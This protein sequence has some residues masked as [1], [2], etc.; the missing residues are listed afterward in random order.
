MTTQQKVIARDAPASSRRRTKSPP[1]P[2][3]G[4]EPSAPNPYCITASPISS[5]SVPFPPPPDTPP[6]LVDAWQSSQPWESVSGRLYSRSSP[7]IS[8]FAPTH[9]STIA[10]HS[11][12]KVLHSLEASYTA[13]PCHPVIQYVQDADTYA[14]PDAGHPPSPTSSSG[15]YMSS[16]LHP[17]SLQS[18]YGYPAHYGLQHSGVSHAPS[19]MSA[20]RISGKSLRFLTKGLIVM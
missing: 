15:G 19:G 5:A 8:P 18:P 2:L 12:A 7:E 1:L 6:P 4:E 20:A 16:Q 13:S 10:P 11:A 9:P 17:I 14:Y 3:I